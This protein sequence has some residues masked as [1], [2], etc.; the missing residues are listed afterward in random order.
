MKE[1]FPQRDEYEWMRREQKDEKKWDRFLVEELE[2]PLQ[3]ILD[4]LRPSLEAGAYTILLGDDASGRIPTYILNKVI[5]KIYQEQGKQK[6]L[7]RYVAGS[8][9]LDEYDRAWSEKRQ[10]IIEQAE[11]M[12]LE[13]TGNAQKA[14]A[15]II[16]DSVDSGKSMRML[17]QALTLAGIEADV[18]TI[19]VTSYGEEWT[20]YNVKEAIGSVNLYIG[21][22]GT[23]GIYWPESKAK[24]LSGVV[25]K[26]DQLFAESR[27]NHPH[28]Y[29]LKDQERVNFARKVGD[30]VAARLLDFYYA[31]EMRKAA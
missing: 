9:G 31:G 16:T 21:Q 2:T 8:T 13:A 10:Q 27:R 7:V 12:K 5:G 19:G 29:V 6:P 1:R 25:K 14:K 3:R 15:L 22:A 18:A 20:Q 23:P 30:E 24:P 17:V 26:P 4:D 11:R 28:A